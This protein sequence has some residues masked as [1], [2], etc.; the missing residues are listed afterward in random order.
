MKADRDQA[1]F[2]APYSAAAE[3]NTNQ[4]LRVMLERALD[5]LDCALLIVDEEGTVQY[6][7]RVAT[8]LLDGAHGGLVVEGGTLTAKG[9]KLRE[10]LAHALALACAELEPS[11]IC[12]PHPGQSPERWLRMV[13]SPIYFGAGSGRCAAIWILNTAAPALPGEE[14]LG[15]LFGLSRAEARLALGLLM[16]RSAAEQARHAGVGL[17]TV[18]SQLHS[19]FCKTGVQR[20]AQ[21]VALLSRVPVI[22]LPRK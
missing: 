20:Q 15:A 13:V 17:A 19:I 4:A 18:R 1:I 3:Q 6:R 21:L 7:N 11:G 22:Q 10:T 5:M 9:R 14:M 2:A 8:A 12:L 16:G